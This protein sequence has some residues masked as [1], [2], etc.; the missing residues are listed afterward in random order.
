MTLAPKVTQ[1]K[2]RS[3]G[4]EGVRGGK[5]PI[6]HYPDVGQ[7]LN[8]DTVADSSTSPRLSPTLGNTH[9]AQRAASSV[10]EENDTNPFG[11]DIIT[12][13]SL[14]NTS[15]SVPELLRTRTDLTTKTTRSGRIF[16]IPKR[17]LGLFLVS[18][19]SEASLPK[20]W[21]PEEARM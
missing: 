2:Y 7:L 13:S 4:V 15:V 9:P 19:A 18:Q 14:Q 3:V 21:E 12:N 20:R 5:K 10:V 8:L 6:E 16:S 1:L 11:S 17:Y